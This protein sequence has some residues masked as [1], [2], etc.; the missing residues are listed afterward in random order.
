LFF[1]AFLFLHKK[2]P[3][4]NAAAMTTI[5][6][7]TAMAIFAPDLRPPPE[8]ESVPE[9]LSAEGVADDDDEVIAEE[10]VSVLA[11]GVV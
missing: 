5:G 2:N 6:M 4:K 3:I 8:F 1:L 9:A 10:V 11:V 7:M